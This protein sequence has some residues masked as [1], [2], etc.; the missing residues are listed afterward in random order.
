MASPDMSEQRIKPTS[1]T[2]THFPIAFNCCSKMVIVNSL[3]QVW[4]Q[5]KQRLHFQALC[6]YIFGHLW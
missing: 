2:L 6:L 4:K 5:A 1:G 3:Q